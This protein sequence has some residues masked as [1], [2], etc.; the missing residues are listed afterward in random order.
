MLIKNDDK[1]ILLTVYE[2]LM[3]KLYCG[4]LN[5]IFGWQSKCFDVKENTF[6]LVN[7]GEFVGNYMFETLIVI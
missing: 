6:T 4:S 7:S 3:P 2:K 1:T 5:P